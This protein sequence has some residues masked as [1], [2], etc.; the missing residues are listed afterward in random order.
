MAK[1][2]KK[3]RPAVPTTSTVS[4][5]GITA[6]A[7]FLFQMMGIAAY[8]VKIIESTPK[9]ANGDLE[10]VFVLEPY[11]QDA[12][13]VSKTQTQ[14][15]QFK[16]SANPQKHGISTAH[17]I[18]IAEK[19]RSSV[20]LAK[21]DNPKIKISY[22]LVTNRRLTPDGK[23]TQS[24]AKNNASSGKLD[25]I[26][27]AKG[28]TKAKNRSYREILKVLIYQ[29]INASKFESELRFASSRLGVNEVE[30]RDG[31]DRL[32]AYFVKLAAEVGSAAFPRSKLDEKLA[33]FA[34]P[35]GITLPEVAAELRKEVTI[36]QGGAKLPSTLYRRAAVDEINAAKT[37]SPVI[38]VYG[39]GGCGKS[40]AIWDAMRDNLPAAPA[41][42]L[43]YLIAD[44]ASEMPSK[45][46]MR[47]IGKWRNAPEDFWGLDTPERSLFRLRIAAGSD[48]RPLVL[49]A[50][51]G[52]DEL[53]EA[54][55]RAQLQ[56]FLR[57]AWDDFMNS[58][59]STPRVILLV[60]CR[61]PDEV[62][63]LLRHRGRAY[64]QYRVDSVTKVS[65]DDFSPT[66][67]RELANR[68]LSVPIARRLNA[69]I[70]QKPMVAPTEEMAEGIAPLAPQDSVD[71][72]VYNAIRHPLLW[73]FFSD[74]D[75][76]TQ[77]RI[78]NGDRAALWILCR[79]YIEW[80]CEKAKDKPFGGNS[81]AVIAML[82]S[83]ASAA[84]PT[85]ELRKR[86]EHWIE[87]AMNTG[88]PLYY[89][90]GLFDEAK[91]FGLIQA[92]F[93]TGTTEIWRWRHAFVTEYLRQP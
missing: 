61:D 35:K 76:A 40:A 82:R 84:P 66:E 20:L 46:L 34:E 62:L 64:L 78:L 13:K 91:S 51:D 59:N 9:T 42:P 69:R 90:N 68:H 70:V 1:K 93:P 81:Q 43:H 11:G 37:K 22:K 65:M 60:T 10:S 53:N 5:G 3:S 67:L 44:F 36:F 83:V 80:F 4:D 38:I 21:R 50:I 72:K 16:Y 74:Q 58:E 57:L 86:Q 31:L 89:A 26:D 23:K 8:G 6:L 73:R 30:F 39:T 25:A 87:P 48:I 47:T 29:Q 88:M 85:D 32:V 17:L 52:F 24:A 54:S 75:S 56:S 19:F 15:V 41:N 77:G 71:E 33:G 45:W 2:A 27:K 79:S 63:R 12:A 28:R 18:D 49:L 7:G 92:D 55:D 14:L